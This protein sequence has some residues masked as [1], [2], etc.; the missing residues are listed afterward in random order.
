[1]RWVRSVA[2]AEEDLS[3][4]LLKNVW[5]VQEREED[6]QE[7]FK[8]KIRQPCMSHARRR[9]FP[10]ILLAAAPKDALKKR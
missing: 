10:L 8:M 3:K 4:V 9:T 5:L 2:V 1:M 6:E 7:G